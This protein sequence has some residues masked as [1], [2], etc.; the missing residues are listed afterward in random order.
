MVSFSQVGVHF[1][2]ERLD[3]ETNFKYNNYGKDIFLQPLDNYCP[4]KICN[5]FKF[6]IEK[7]FLKCSL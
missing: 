2:R 7:I 5:K 3:L 1:V 4:Y 6:L